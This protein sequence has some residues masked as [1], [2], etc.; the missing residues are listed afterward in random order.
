LSSAAAEDASALQARDAGG[1]GGS[2]GAVLLEAGRSMQ[3]GSEVIDVTG[4]LGGLGAV[5]NHGGSGGSGVVRFN[6]PTGTES[7][8]FLET[9]VTPDAAVQSDPVASNDIAN[10][11]LWV[12][13]ISPGQSATLTCKAVQSSMVMLVVYVRCGMSLLRSMQVTLISTKSN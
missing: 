7:I 6:T 10:V 4:G 9:F 1:G 3:L 12:I 11:A 8:A 2:G 13:T 5:G